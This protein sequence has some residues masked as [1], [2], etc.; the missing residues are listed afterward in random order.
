MKYK[1]VVVGAGPAGIAVVGNLLEQ[2]K[3]PLLWVDDDFEG[4][5]LNKCY[6]QV[7]SNT[8]AKLFVAYANGVSIFRTISKTTPEPNAISQ[9]KHLDQEKTCHIAEAADMCLMLSKRLAKL[10][11]VTAQ[12]GRWIVRVDARDGNSPSHITASAEL[13]VLCTGSIPATQPL[14]TTLLQDIALDDGLNPTLLSK[15]LS[16]G[17]HATVAVIG[18]SHSAILVLM[19][20]CNLASTTHPNLCIK[21]FSRHPLRYA[22]ERNGT[23]IRDNT[24]LKGDVA[25]WARA[26]LEEHKLPKSSISRYLQKIRTTVGGERAEYSAHLPACTHVI[27][28]IGFIRNPLP[29]LTV[30]GATLQQLKHISATAGFE[31]ENGAALSGLY[32]AGIAWPEKVVDL[33]GNVEYAVGLAKFM[34]YLKRVVPAWTGIQDSQTG[35]LHLCRSLALGEEETIVSSVQAALGYESRL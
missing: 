27:Q 3:A 9:L 32:G 33:E 35:N 20:L 26:N 12:D 10:D 28:A 25:T 34:R 23:I 18:A 14:L 17:T 13:L 4:G 29:T 16:S 21:W 19:N 31:D 24:G 15:I 30:N 6:R 2:H 22:E 1:A 7:P 11:E 5:R 8:K